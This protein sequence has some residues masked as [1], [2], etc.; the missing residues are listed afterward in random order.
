MKIPTRTLVNMHYIPV[1]NEFPYSMDTVTIVVS[2]VFNFR[3]VVQC[4]ISEYGNFRI[5]SYISLY[6]WLE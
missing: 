2:I 6:M 1:F 5:M 3:L 4:L